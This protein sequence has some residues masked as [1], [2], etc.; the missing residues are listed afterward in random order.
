MK[1]L[2]IQPASTR[3]EELISTL[4]GI[5]SIALISLASYRL[6]GL[7]AT[8]AIV[9]SMGASAVLLFAVPHGPLSQP[10]ALFMGHFVSAI[11]GVT[12]AQWV[13]D[14]IIASGLAVGFAIGAMLLCRCTHPPGGAT[15]LA[16]VIGGDAIHQLG[17]FYV[18]VP[19]LLNCLVIFTVAISFNNFFPWRRYPASAMHYKPINISSNSPIPSRVYLAQALQDHHSLLDIS[20]SDLQQ[21]YRHAEELRLA[22]ILNQFDFEPGAHYTNGKPG[23]DW[24]IRRI[25]DYTHHPDPHKDMIIYKV[26]EGSHKNSTSNCTRAEFALWAKQKLAPSK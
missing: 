21:I 12:V 8:L 22:E 13:P 5:L 4:G 23:K 10:W 14:M 20:P 17:Y 3:S 7:Q 25:I 2:G 19:V 18:L 1:W 26:V 24:A 11:I 9:P 16:A 6:L 15:A